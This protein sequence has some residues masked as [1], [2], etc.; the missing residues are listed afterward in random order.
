MPLATNTADL[1][2]S[3]EPTGED[4]DGVSPLSFLDVPRK[5]HPERPLDAPEISDGLASQT[6]DTV[7]LP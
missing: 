2:S 3:F 1:L 6:T 4:D 7:T 5:T